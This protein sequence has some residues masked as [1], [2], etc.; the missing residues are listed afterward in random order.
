M[1]AIADE[2]SR[3]VILGT[4]PGDE[5]LRQQRYYGN[6][7]NLFWR[8]LATALEQPIGQTY[9]EKLQF[10]ADAGIA[11]WDVAYSAER[12]GS[13]D[14]AIREPIPNDFAAFFSTYRDLRKVG[15]NGVKAATLWR[16]HVRPQRDV[17]HSELKCTELPSTSATPGRYVKP[18]EEKVVLWRAFLR[19]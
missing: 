19:P 11:L 14:T 15:F 5:S 9:A 3:V 4:L 18:F 10:L 12:E 7:S 6:P 2:R 17:P 13:L 8:I 1:P 16:K